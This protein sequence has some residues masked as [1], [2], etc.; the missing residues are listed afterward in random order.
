MIRIKKG[1]YGRRVGDFVYPVRTGETCALDAVEE[2]TLVRIGVA[3]YV[4]APKAEAK[5]PAPKRKKTVTK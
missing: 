5:Q 2:E 3:E 4:E 1:V